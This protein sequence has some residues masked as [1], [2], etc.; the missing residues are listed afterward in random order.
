MFQEQQQKMYWLVCIMVYHNFL[1]Y[2]GWPWSAKHDKTRKLSLICCLRSPLRVGA[3]VTFYD[4]F[5]VPS[6][7]FCISGNCA[8]L[9]VAQKDQKTKK[10]CEG[11]L[12]SSKQKKTNSVTLKGLRSFLCSFSFFSLLFLFSF[13]F[14][15]G[16]NGFLFCF[17]FC[18]NVSTFLSFFFGFSIIFFVFL[19]TTPVPD[20]QWI[21]PLILLETWISQPNFT[22]MQL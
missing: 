7:Q 20:I 10:Y 13:L 18:F 11:V 4:D 3:G 17:L 2:L 9:T 15:W 21:K 5:C 12:K 1:G 8:K 14:C 22:A 19:L 6:Q 16:G